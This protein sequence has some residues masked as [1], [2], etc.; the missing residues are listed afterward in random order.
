M[1]VLILH[2]LAPTT[3]G[4]GR[5]VAE[6]DLSGAVH[7]LRSVLPEAGVAAVRGEVREVLDALETYRPDVEFN[8]CEAPLGRPDLEAHVAAL[9]EWLGIPFTGSGSATLALC[10]RKDRINAVLTAAGVAVPRGGVFPCI[11]KPADEDGS[12]GIDEHSICDDVDQVNYAK[13][14]INGPVVVEEFL[15]GEEFVVSLWGRTEPEHLS[16]AR[17]EFTNDLRINTYASKWLKESSDYANTCLTPHIDLPEALRLGETAR[18]V[19]A[20]GYMGVDLRLDSEG[21]PRVLDVNPN[22][23]LGQGEGI[24]Q[25]VIEAGWTWERFVRQQ[26]EWA[27]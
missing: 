11:V 4:P 7:G 27:Q 9:L 19:G 24:H 26:I 3:A 6:F 25:A 12:A 17:M 23:D 8:A 22:P 21:M 20:R 5:N 16:L 1:K 18:A 14:R 15:S 10:R 13:S 2:S